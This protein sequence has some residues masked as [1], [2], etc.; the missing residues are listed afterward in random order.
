MNAATNF[1]VQPAK[2]A[3][4]WSQFRGASSPATPY[5]P[6]PIRYGHL[7]AGDEAGQLRAQV[8]ELFSEADAATMLGWQR[9]AQATIKVALQSVKDADWS[10]DPDE[11]K[12]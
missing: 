2:T 6:A 10:L 3:E 1:I 4:R 8:A 11:M 9:P 7:G 12:F 5:P